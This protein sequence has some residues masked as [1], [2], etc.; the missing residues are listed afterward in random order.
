MQEGEEGGGGRGGDSGKRRRGVAMR[1]EGGRENREG[2][3]RRSKRCMRR[4]EGEGEEMNK[5]EV[6]ERKIGVKEK[7]KDE[8]LS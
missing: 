6:K 2:P 5:E 7:N 1:V 4:R 3:K 8:L